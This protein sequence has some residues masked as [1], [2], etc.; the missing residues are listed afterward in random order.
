MLDKKR[1]LGI[2][3]KIAKLKSDTLQ[4]QMLDSLIRVSR[5]M[6]GVTNA[7]LTQFVHRWRLCAEPDDD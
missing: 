3:A 4:T 6:E 7:V 5:Q 1:S 2:H